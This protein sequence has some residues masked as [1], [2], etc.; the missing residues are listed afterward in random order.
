V[1]ASAGLP[2]VYAAMQAAALGDP[3]FVAPDPDLAD[4]LERR[5]LGSS[6][7][8]LKGMADA[9]RSEPDRVPELRATAVPGLVTHGT[10]DDAWLPAVQLDMAE[11][12]GARYVVIAGAAHSPAVENAEA[13]AAVLTEFWRG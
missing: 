13:T 11:R 8:M 4:F 12:L 9:L 3:Q 6:P 10:D 1:L 2:G 7:E 5:F